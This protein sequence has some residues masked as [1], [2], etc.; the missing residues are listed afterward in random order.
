MRNL[1]RLSL[2]VGL[3]LMCLGTAHADY[4]KGTTMFQIYGGGA[5]LH[6]HY[7]QVFVADDEKEYADPGGV[8]GGQFL[9]FIDD[10]PCLAVG[11]DISHADFD[12]H[13]SSQL[14]ANRF[15]RSSA[16]NTTGLAIV[17]LSYPKGHFR[18]YV[19]GG[20]GVHHTSLLLEGVPINASSWSDTST[21][22]TR[23]LFDDGHAGAALEGAIG[24]H[25]FFTER[26]FVGAEFKVLGLFGKD[27]QPTSAGVLEGMRN[28]QGAISSSG[29]GLMIGLGF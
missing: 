12:N 13:D 22:E 15:T 23:R 20:V 16:K 25:I 3:E 6:G 7:S 18:P 24:M 28:S 29:I 9:Y 27:F 21:T 26:F 5:S 1:K 17:R 11:F 14:L 19:Q 4:T 8:I 2:F 10:S